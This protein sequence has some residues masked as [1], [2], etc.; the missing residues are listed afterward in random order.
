[1]VQRVLSSS[2]LRLQI[3]WKVSIWLFYMITCYSISG[4]VALFSERSGVFLG[5]ILQFL[6]W[7]IFLAVSEGLAFML[8]ALGQNYSPPT[9]AAIILSLGTLTIWIISRR[10]LMSIPCLNRKIEYFMCRAHTVYSFTLSF[11]LY[12]RGSLRGSFQLCFSGR[13]TEQPW[14]GGLRANV[15]GHL[16]REGWHRVPIYD[17]SLAGGLWF[18]RNF[19]GRLAFR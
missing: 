3:V 7:M 13:A 1:M 11:Y 18:P 15:A 16:Y 14:V 17:V 10:I 19:Y 12:H 6:P 5:H 4:C 2:L 9:H 8:M